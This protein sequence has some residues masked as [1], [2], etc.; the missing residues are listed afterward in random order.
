MKN[1]KSALSLFNIDE[2]KQ[3]H[4]KIN[5]YENIEL[6]L[7]ELNKE[8]SK[9]CLESLQK[10]QY[11]FS[12]KEHYLLWSVSEVYGHQIK[13][14]IANQILPKNDIPMFY[15]KGYLFTFTNNYQNRLW[16]EKADKYGIN[17][18]D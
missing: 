12:I 9:Y 6:Y 1:L 5:S 16:F 7:D 10:K 11:I 15:Y 4:E 17:F 3:L 2:V 13:E 18:K 14:D 8:Y